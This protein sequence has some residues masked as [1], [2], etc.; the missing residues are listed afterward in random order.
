MLDYLIKNAI[1]VDGTGTPGTP[2]DLGI[3]GG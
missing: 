3:Q 1:L 2:G